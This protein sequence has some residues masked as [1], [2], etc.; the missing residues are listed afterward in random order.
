MLHDAQDCMH[1]FAC[2]LRDMHVK[3]YI[4]VKTRS[5]ITNI[6]NQK[7]MKVLKLYVMCKTTCI[8]L[9][10]L[11]ATWMWNFIFMLGLRVLS[12]I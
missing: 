8:F 4:H 11:C 5:P 12:Q 2:A 6:K 9:H 7:K 1:I 3:F 10:A